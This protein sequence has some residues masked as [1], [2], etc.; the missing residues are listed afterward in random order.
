MKL[1]GESG[2]PVGNTAHCRH[3]IFVQF[4]KL[5]NLNALVNEWPEKRLTGNASK[6]GGQHPTAIWKN[7]GGVYSLYE[8]SLIKI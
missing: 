2:H 4:K 1:T 8:V 3:S 6:I 5:V 7:N